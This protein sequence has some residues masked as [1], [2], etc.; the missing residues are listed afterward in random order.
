[1]KVSERVAYLLAQAQHPVVDVVIDREQNIH[2][3]RADLRGITE[4]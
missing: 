4:T 3:Y 2:T 1:M